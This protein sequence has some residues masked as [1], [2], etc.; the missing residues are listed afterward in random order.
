MLCRERTAAFDARGGVASHY[1]LHQIHSIV[2]DDRIVGG[3]CLGEI[4]VVRISVALVH[5]FVDQDG[6]LIVL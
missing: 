4:V 5:A 1:G 3:H 6:R 2:D